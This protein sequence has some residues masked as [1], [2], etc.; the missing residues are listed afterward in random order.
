MVVALGYFG[1]PPMPGFG[2][3]I[4]RKERRRIVACTW[5][6]TKFPCRAPQGTTL[7][8]CFLSGED[9]P[10]IGA[11]HAELKDLAGV[12][13]EPRFYRIFHW[14]RARWRSMAWATRSA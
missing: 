4:P 13:G 9:E 5:V 11:V 6:G 1:P 8:R 14:P 7:A 3:L 10:D 12:R 2:F